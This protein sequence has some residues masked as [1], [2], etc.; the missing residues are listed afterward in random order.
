MAEAKGTKEVV[1]VKK[2]DHVAKYAALHRFQGQEYLVD[3]G[4]SLS[5]LPEAL[6]TALVTEGLARKA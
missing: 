3:A 2:D 4:D 5:E 6:V 1:P